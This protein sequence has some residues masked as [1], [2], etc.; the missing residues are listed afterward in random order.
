MANF[1][2]KG[3]T[4]F[5]LITLA[6]ASCNN[7]HFTE[8]PE[9]DRYVGPWA[10][11]NEGGETSPNSIYIEKKGEIYNCYFLSAKGEYKQYKGIIDKED[12]KIGNDFTLK[13]IAE[14][15]AIYLVENS[16][17]YIRMKTFESTL[18]EIREDIKSVDG[19]NLSHFIFIPFTD[20][21]SNAYNQNPN[22]S[23]TKRDNIGAGTEKLFDKKVK[24]CFMNPEISSYYDLDKDE[25]LKE[26]MGVYIN[27]WE[28][29]F[30]CQNS[31]GRNLTFVFSIRNNEYN[32][33]RLQYF[34]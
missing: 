5:I 31:T 23:M 25:I 22:Y 7:S 19:A 3:F 8:A 20:D 11:E 10:S 16:M 17:T 2:N 9:S 1:F 15:K 4:L 28:Y 6:F 21:M 34:P 29:T 27:P 14:N 30:S 32:A 24:E 12:L 26:T 33:I 18:G 13:Y